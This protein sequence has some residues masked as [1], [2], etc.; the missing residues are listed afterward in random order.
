MGIAEIGVR[1][2]NQFNVCD[3]GNLFFLDFGGNFR[4][5]FI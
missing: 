4:G 2:C 1:Y 3:R 5:Q